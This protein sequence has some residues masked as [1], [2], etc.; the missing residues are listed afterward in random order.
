MAR[1]NIE[2]LITQGDQLVKSLAE[3]IIAEAKIKQINN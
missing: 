2:V 3:P 1:A